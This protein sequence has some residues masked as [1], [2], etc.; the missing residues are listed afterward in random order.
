MAIRLK[1]AEV[2][3]LRLIVRNMSRDSAIY[4]MLKSEL[5]GLGHWKNR[6]RRIPKSGFVGTD[7]DL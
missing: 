1:R 3:R 2:E 7:T 6:P 5:S 4:K